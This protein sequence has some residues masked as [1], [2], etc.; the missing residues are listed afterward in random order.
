MN[1]NDILDLFLIICS[2][3]V[4]L[5]HFHGSK[6][7]TLFGVPGIRLTLF[8][9]PGIRSLDDSEWEICLDAWLLAIDVLVHLECFIFISSFP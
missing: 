1:P 9:V 2:F 3:D 5:I 7:S 6:L 4:R 8:G